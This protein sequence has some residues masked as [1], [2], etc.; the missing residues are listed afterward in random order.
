[1]RSRHRT[2]AGPRTSSRRR[3]ARTTAAPVPTGRPPWA[4]LAVG[5]ILTACSSTPG[6]KIEIDHASIAR[7]RDAGYTHR[8]DEGVIRQ[9]VGAP[10]SL[11]AWHVTLVSLPGGSLRPLIVY[12]PALGD[13]DDTP[14]RWED[15]WARAG[16]A[17][18]AVQALDEDARV[19]STESA[20]SGDFEQVARSRFTDELMDQRLARLAHLLAQLRQRTQ[21]GAAELA[22]LDWARLALAGADLGAY[23]VQTIATLTA[24]RRAEL[25]WPVQPRG[26]VAISPHGRSTPGPASAAT[27]A[28]AP[29]LMI[30]SRDDV[31]AYGVITDVALRHQAFDRLAGGDDYY[32]EFAS[33]SHRWL[34]GVAPAAAAEAPVHRASPARQSGPPNRGAGADR[35]APAEDDEL[36]PEARARAVAGRAEREAQAARLLGRQLTQL[37][38]SEI[39]FEDVTLAFFDAH[40]RQDPRAGRWL[41]EQ[42]ADWLKNGDRIKHR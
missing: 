34:A 1:M 14:C 41:A 11:A 4:G 20:R 24:D 27:P 36:S 12:L 40:L 23:T 18:L 28:S 7:Y 42:A 2:V 38:M 19:W 29:V 16:Y 26:Y 37:E 15:V 22:G 6:V 39:G 3:S 31:D 33:A 10:D 30:S 25:G 13:G 5:L 35:L 9:R 8:V 32:L 21:S 17:V